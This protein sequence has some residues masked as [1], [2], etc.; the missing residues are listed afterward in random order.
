MRTASGV[1]S[2]TAGNT[3]RSCD[4]SSFARMHSC[5]EAFVRG[6]AFP[7]RFQRSAREAFG[8][9]PGINRASGDGALPAVGAMPQ[10]Q[11][12]QNGFSRCLPINKS[13]H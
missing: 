7:L 6:R 4:K 9:P 5:P 3:C 12:G 2:G 8:A 1:I 10:Q 13:R 11:A